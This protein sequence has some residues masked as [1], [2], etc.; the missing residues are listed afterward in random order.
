LDY[1]E[2]KPVVVAKTETRKSSERKRER[3]SEI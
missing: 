2:G 1:K 3:E